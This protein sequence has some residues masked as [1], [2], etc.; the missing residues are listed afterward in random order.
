MRRLLVSILVTS[1]ACSFLMV[2]HAPPERPAACSAPVSAPLLDL[3]GLFFVSGGLIGTGGAIDAASESSAS[4]GT[5]MI[6]GG[7][8][9]GLIYVVS[10]VYGFANLG[11]CPAMGE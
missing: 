5:A 8:L 10:S 9:A 3:G 4:L 6:V 11:S 2:H 1:S 7:A